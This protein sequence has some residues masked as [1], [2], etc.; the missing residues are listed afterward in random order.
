VPPDD[1]PAT[2]ELRRHLERMRVL[3]EASRAF[4]E[5]VGDPGG[6]LKTIARACS[7]LVGDFSSITMIR[8]DGWLQQ[9]AIDHPDPELRADYLRLMNETG[10]VRPGEGVMGR[11]LQNGTPLLL[12]EV[13]PEEIAA[14]APAAFRAFSLRLNVCSF[15]GVPMHARGRVIGGI[16]MARS[17]PGL[18]YTEADVS[19]LQDLADRAA[20]AY[21][22]ARL[23]VGLERRVAEGTA[24]LVR[25]NQELATSNAELEAFSY[26][27]AHDLRTPLRGIDGFSQALVEDCGDVLGELGQSHLR[28]I[29]EGAQR[30]DG[31]INDLLGL[32]RISRGELRRQRVDVT[33]VARAVL[34]RLGEAHPERKVEVVVEPGL[35][36]N[37]DPRLLEIALTNLL[38]NA[39]K[40]TRGRQGARIELGTRAAEEGRVFFVR[41]NGAGFDMQYASKLFGAFQRM[42]SPREFEGTGIGLA[43]VQRIV[44]RHGG[45][46]RAEAA[47]DRGATFSFTLGA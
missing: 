17:R 11:V 23:Y 38:G 4:A 9:T 8:D 34:A 47:V 7:Q 42:H 37:A 27:V 45:S 41:D 24:Q 3:Y 39:W 44:R 5:E 6:L 20:L 15:V 13:N 35:E 18:S 16:S 36:A 40:F 19:Y 46:I 33:A 10:A 32:S 22:N 25:A 2:D 12:P 21:E 30:M 29:R 28:R 31:L 26:S 14:R 43:T 1:A